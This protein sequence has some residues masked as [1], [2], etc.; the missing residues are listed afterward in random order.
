MTASIRIVNAGNCEGDVV[1]IHHGADHAKHDTLTLGAV[2][3]RLSA[4]QTIRVESVHAGRS[5]GDV[6]IETWHDPTGRAQ[7][8]YERFCSGTG[9]G[10][11]HEDFA[12]LEQWEKAGWAAAGG[13]PFERNPWL[14]EDDS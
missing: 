13:V 10:V 8:V 3:P 4:D 11:E 2:S 12:D 5:A 7:E 6:H 1:T 14:P 9:P